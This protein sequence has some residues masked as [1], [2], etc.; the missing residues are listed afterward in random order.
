MGDGGRETVHQE[1]HLTVTRSVRFGRAVWGFEGECSAKVRNLKGLLDGLADRVSGESLPLMIDLRSASYVASPFIGFLVTLV[2][3]LA[4]KGRVL[5]LWGPNDRVLDLLGI[6]GIADGLKIL[7]A[8]E[9]PPAAEA[10]A[11][12]K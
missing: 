8:E 5:E 6:V 3:R 1:E 4:D 10:A 11:S 7:P 2:A 12:G 9:E